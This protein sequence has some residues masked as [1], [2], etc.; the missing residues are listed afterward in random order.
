MFGV[1]D[2]DQRRKNLATQDQATSPKDTEND[3]VIMTSLGLILS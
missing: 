1:K 2:V 3:I